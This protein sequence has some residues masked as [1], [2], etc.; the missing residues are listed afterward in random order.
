MPR[1]LASLALAILSGWI[2]AC[3]T[4]STGRDATLDGDF[5]SDAGRG[6]GGRWQVDLAQLQRHGWSRW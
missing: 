1:A 4:E 2:A 3:G 6:W 5:S